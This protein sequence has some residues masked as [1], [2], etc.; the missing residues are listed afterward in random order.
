MVLDHN[1]IADLPPVRALHEFFNAK[2]L[3]SQVKARQGGGT[4]GGA[5]TILISLV[6]TFFAF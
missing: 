2:S 3:V 1:G 4:P 5:P 6:Y